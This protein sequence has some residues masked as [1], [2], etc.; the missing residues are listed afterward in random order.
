MFHAKVTLPESHPDHPALCK[1]SAV[2]GGLYDVQMILSHSIKL[3]KEKNSQPSRAIYILK[4]II[5]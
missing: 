4:N 1:A 3:I 2:T 5:C